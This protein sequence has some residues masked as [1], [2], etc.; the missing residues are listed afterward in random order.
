MK[1]QSFKSMDDLIQGIKTIISNYRCSFSD[2]EQVLL[3]ECISKL[4]ES[5]AEPDPQ[6]QLQA[7]AKVLGTLLRIFTLIDHFKDLF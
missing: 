3:K 1:N 2:E 7:S 6:N 5:R 4:E